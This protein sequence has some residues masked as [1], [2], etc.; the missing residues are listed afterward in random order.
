MQAPHLEYIHAIYMYTW[1]AKCSTLLV[2]VWVF[3]THGAGGGTPMGHTNSPP[4]GDRQHRRYIK[5]V[6]SFDAAT[7]VNQ[8]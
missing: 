3:V 6:L 4:A 2:D 5:F 8:L 7:A 1:H